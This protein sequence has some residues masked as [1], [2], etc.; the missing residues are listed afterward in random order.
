ME[1]DDD[2]T[3]FR[4]K[5]GPSP[6][7]KRKQSPRVALDFDFGVQ[8]PEQPL[9]PKPKRKAH[10][11]FQTLRPA[12][13]DENAYFEE[14]SLNRN[15][16]SY[17]PRNQKRARTLSPGAQKRTLHANRAARDNTKK[18]RWEQEKE[19]RRERRERAFLR[20]VLTEVPPADA[21]FN[22][23]GFASTMHGIPEESNVPEEM[24]TP[25]ET[26]ISEERME[27][28][29][30]QEE[31][32][33]EDP[34][35]A[36][37]RKMAELNADRERQREREKHLKGEEVK[38]RAQSE[39]PGREQQKQ[40]KL[41]EEKRR[42]EE[43]ARRRKEFEKIML[44]EEIRRRR[45]EL[46]ERLNRERELRHEQWSSGYWSHHRAVERYKG[47]SAFFD[48]ARFSGE[49]FPLV[50][51]DIPWPTLKDPR[52]NKVQDLDWD[53][54]NAFF[55]YFRKNSRPQEYKDILRPQS[56]HLHSR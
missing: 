17:I 31:E 1:V 16:K 5:S 34:L 45:A 33:P 32:I 21:H 42:K 44:E 20:E 39:D 47:V 52:R 43:E 26:S 51:I 55:S 13:D 56:L 24:N 37:L 12:D 15:T 49:T 54:V 10:V 14:D 27:D 25:D 29:T 53:V 40:Q 18:T 23:N 30:S 6:R 48:K 9:D 8:P 36:S 50:F 11:S 3:P 7:R 2:S 22:G 35:A 46:F 28:P 19:A 4:P 41:A 38:R